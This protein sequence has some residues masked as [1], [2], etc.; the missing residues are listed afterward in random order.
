MPRGSRV[1]LLRGNS[2]EIGRV[3]DKDGPGMA[4]ATAPGAEET[5]ETELYFHSVV[6]FLSRKRKDKNDRRAKNE[7][8]INC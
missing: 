3:L 2:T 6:S 8:K 5:L 1:R 4:A 7:G